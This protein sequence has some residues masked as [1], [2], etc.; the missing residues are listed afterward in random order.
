MTAMWS[1]LI[2]SGLGFCSEPPLPA[3]EKVVAFS[4]YQWAVRSPRGAV[5]PGPNL[6]SDSSRNVWVD[7]A[8]RLHLKIT[9]DGGRWTCAEVALDR[10]LG[11][12]TY[13]LLLDSELERLDDRSVL[14]FFTWDDRPLE[15]HREM[16][17][18]LSKWA[19]PRDRN[20]QF[21]VV[22]TDKKVR[23]NV[24][25]ALAPTAYRFT[26]SPGRVI[27][28][29][30]GARSWDYA[31]AG[32]PSSGTARIKL[33]LWLFR[34]QAPSSGREVEAIVDAFTFQPPP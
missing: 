5:G 33:N 4:G 10:S 11:Y 34:G 16:D 32:V 25:P 9:H 14:G 12:G 31:D 24:L 26:W 28:A 13:T 17:I 6:F 19:Q 18:E 22:P 8:G 15:E 23:F 27:F 3:A 29:G 2:L 1:L 21:V 30:A 20:A 7:E